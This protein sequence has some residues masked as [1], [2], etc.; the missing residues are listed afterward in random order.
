LAY[1]LGELA[2]LSI[3]GEVGEIVNGIVYSREEDA[4]LYFVVHTRGFPFAGRQDS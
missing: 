2:G 3:P 1:V 4:V